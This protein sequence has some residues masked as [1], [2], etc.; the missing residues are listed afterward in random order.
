MGAHT[1]AKAGSVQMI[2]IGY[3]AL[4]RTQHRKDFRHMLPMKG[5]DGHPHK[6][7]G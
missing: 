5:V 4:M 7:V 6:L 2:A 1:Y 3:L